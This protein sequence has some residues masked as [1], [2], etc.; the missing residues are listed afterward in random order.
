MSKPA[1][2]GGLLFQ[3]ED[4]V[5]NSGAWSEP[6]V[7]P[8][9]IPKP[10]HFHRIGEIAARGLAIR[11]R[12]KRGRVERRNAKRGAYFALQTGM[13]MGRRAYFTLCIQA[14]NTLATSAILSP[15]H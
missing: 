1:N 13:R 3:C 2:L 9:E 11:I 7:E 15:E 14:V 10:T 6:G 5:V 12:R 8:H 4:F